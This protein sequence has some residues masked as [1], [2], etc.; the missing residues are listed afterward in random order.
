MENKTPYRPYYHDLP[1]LTP[2]ERKSYASR[3]VNSTYVELQNCE[4]PETHDERVLRYMRL[5]TTPLP[6]KSFFARLWDRLHFGRGS[7]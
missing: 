6:K 4:H 5:L 1:D 3:I 7:K 2:E